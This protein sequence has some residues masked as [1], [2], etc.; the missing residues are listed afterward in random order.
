MIIC[1][2]RKINSKHNNNLYDSATYPCGA[3]LALW[4]YKVL[5]S[6]FK[7][8]VCSFGLLSMRGGGGGGKN[9]M[10]K[11]NVQAVTDPLT[12]D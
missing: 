8:S 9:T 6:K 12:E 7:G 5:D 1:G 4:V 2:S 10:R 11:V 3:N